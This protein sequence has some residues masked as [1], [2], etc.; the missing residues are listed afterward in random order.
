GTY[1]V[2]GATN[3]YG[4][5]TTIPSPTSTG[6]I[7][8]ISGTLTLNGAGTL[9]VPTLTI[10]GGTLTG[11]A[12]ITFTST[13]MSWTGGTISGSGLMTIPAAT[14]V[15]VTGAYLDGRAL[16]NSGTMAFGAG[17][18]YMQNN[19]TLANGGTIDFTGDGGLAMNGT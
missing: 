9:N 1:N 12:P 13:P 7:S 2:T 5:T 6:A 14:T 16:T 4:A 15:N 10:S 3:N 18:L 8:V 17:Y 19:A 11:T